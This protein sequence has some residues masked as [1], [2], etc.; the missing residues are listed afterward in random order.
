MAESSGIALDTTDILVEIDTLLALKYQGR[1]QE[2][3]SQIKS[4]L[5]RLGSLDLQTAISLTYEK[6]DDPYFQSMAFEEKQ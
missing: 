4:W 3:N 5:V 2:I 6:I 1:Q